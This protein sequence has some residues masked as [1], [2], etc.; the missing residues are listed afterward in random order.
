MLVQLDRRACH[1][2]RL[3]PSFLLPLS[4][5]NII[6]SRTNS[7]KG[8]MFPAT[9][10]HP[11]ATCA[12][13][14]RA[15][16]DGIEASQMPHRRRW[17]TSMFPKAG[18]QISPRVSRDSTP[19]NTSALAGVAIVRG[20]RCR[21]YG[22]PSGPK[23]KRTFVCCPDDIFCPLVGPIKSHTQDCITLHS[24]RSLKQPPEPSGGTFIQNWEFLPTRST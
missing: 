6:H 21:G 15:V 10:C 2:P 17:T 23:N 16:D 14:T 18:V 20:P 13:V 9:I 1:N 4:A 3:C 8:S 12:C 22:W 7:V 5:S 24:F 19:T 11:P